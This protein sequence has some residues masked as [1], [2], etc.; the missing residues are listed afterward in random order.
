LLAQPSRAALTC[1]KYV[2]L[3]VRAI[4]DA[5]FRATIRNG[6]IVLPARFKEW[7][8]AHHGAHVEIEHVKP[9]RSISQLRMYRSWLSGVAIH[10]GN[11][12]EALHEFLLDR[13]APR[14]VVTIRGPKGSV[15]VE[16][17][18]RTSGGHT[19][20]MSKAEMVEFLDKCAALTGYPLPTDEELAALGYVKGG[21]DTKPDYPEV[22]GNLADKF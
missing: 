9:E 6:E 18:K 5:M 17:V 15:E 2:A 11:D 16:R 12:E 20:S 19:L 14:V 8:A 21:S 3:K 22:E 10:S 13:C 1:V 4:G 7:A